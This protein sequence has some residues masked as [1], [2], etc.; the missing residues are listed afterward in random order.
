MQYLHYAFISPDIADHYKKNYTDHRIDNTNLII[1]HLI[2]LLLKTANKFGGHCV[3]LD[4][5]FYRNGYLLFF[6]SKITISPVMWVT[7]CPGK[8]S[9]IVCWPN[10]FIPNTIP[11]LFQSCFFMISKWEVVIIEARDVPRK[12]RILSNMSQILIYLTKNQKNCIFFCKCSI[13]ILASMSLMQSFFSFLFNSLGQNLVKLQFLNWNLTQF[14]VK[15][16]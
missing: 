15:K 1:L 10:S 3:K 9:V 12:F 13:I 5:Y 16:P 7:F 4:F 11:L 8:M 6:G 14:S 2:S